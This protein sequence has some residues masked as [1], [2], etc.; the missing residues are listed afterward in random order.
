MFLRR[1][2]YP[3]QAANS[4]AI[5]PDP[6]R[7]DVSVTFTDLLC[8]KY[9]DSI[10]GSRTCQSRD[11]D[12][13]RKMHHRRSTFPFAI[14]LFVF[15]LPS[16][17]GELPVA[18]SLPPRPAS[19]LSW[20]TFKITSLFLLS[21]SATG[22]KTCHRVSSVASSLIHHSSMISGA[23]NCTLLQYFTSC[24]ILLPQSTSSSLRSSSSS[25]TSSCRSSRTLCLSRRQP[26]SLP[27][28]VDFFFSRILFWRTD[29]RG[30]LY[31]KVDQNGSTLERECALIDLAGEFVALCIKKVFFFFNFILLF[32]ITFYIAMT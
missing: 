19:S 13:S 23:R 16:L 26:S 9:E 17:R 4:F 3:R 7:R 29:R 1:F 8:G 18:N 12:Y 24:T 10:P 31:L 21:S 5:D 22:S 30:Y 20:Q 14:S 32:N 25:S 27:P 11:L 6:H 28:A 2:H 15:P